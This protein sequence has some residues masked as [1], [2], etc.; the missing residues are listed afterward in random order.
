MKNLLMTTA[1]VAFAG[2][3][4]ANNAEDLTERLYG[5][6]GDIPLL[7]SNDQANA[8]ATHN[9]GLRIDRLEQEDQIRDG[10]LGVTRNLAEDNAGRITTL[11]ENGVGEKGDAGAVGAT[12][13][14][15]IQGATGATGAAGVDGQDAR[16]NAVS[17]THLTLPTILRV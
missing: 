15:G 14:Q 10:I 6:D 8:T 12:G 2:V 13:A 4:N 1:L 5:Y 7:E 11:E 3:V 17:Y 9:Q 16:I